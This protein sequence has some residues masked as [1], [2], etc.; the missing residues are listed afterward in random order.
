MAVTT[1]DIV[2]IMCNPWN[3]HGGNRYATYVFAMK[4]VEIDGVRTFGNT[5]VA[6]VV[7]D[8]GWLPQV[9][10]AITGWIPSDVFWPMPEPEVVQPEAEMEVQEPDSLDEWFES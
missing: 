6:R 9:A 10:D 7:T 5:Q 1:G 2:F 8:H 4:S 3:G